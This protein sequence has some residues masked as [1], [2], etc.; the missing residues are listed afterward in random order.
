MEISYFTHSFSEELHIIVEH[1]LAR[2]ESANK[3]RQEY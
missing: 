2:I 3:F 1:I